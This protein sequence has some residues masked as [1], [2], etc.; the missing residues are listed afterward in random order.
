MPPKRRA[1]LVAAAKSPS[2]STSRAE[3]LSRRQKPHYSPEV[4]S[5]DVTDATG[6]ATIIL[7]IQEGDDEPATGVPPAGEKTQAS[8]NDDEDKLSTD[9]KDDADEL[10]YPDLDKAGLTV[11][12]LYVSNCLHFEPFIGF[13]K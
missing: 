6:D 2:A 12:S 9:E 7:N 5:A 4:D 8:K 10:I 1:A 13:F 3:R 11:S